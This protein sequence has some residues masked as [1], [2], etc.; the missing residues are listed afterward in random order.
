MNIGIVIT[1][2]R[3]RNKIIKALKEEQVD[4][5]FINLIDDNWLD[6]FKGQFDGYLIYPPSFPYEWKNLFF[7]RLYYINDLIKDRMTPNL[8]AISIYE[9]KI[10][11]HDFYK[12]NN[13]PHI[14]ANTFYNLQDALEYSHGCKLP[15][16]VKEDEGS[17]SVGV[18][19]FKDRKKL[20][21]M[22]KKSFY[23]N[24]QIT[25]KLNFKNIKSKLSPYKKNFNIALN[26]KWNY[27]PSNTKRVG[28][29]HIQSYEKIKY[30]WRIIR[31]GESYF[32][33]KK[34]EDEEGFHSGSLRKG[35]G[36]IPIQ[37]LN[38]VKEVSD[39]INFDNT[40]FDLFETS[41]GEL[42]FNEIQVMFGVSTEEQLIVNNVPGRYIF[43]NDNWIFDPGNYSRN[44]CNNMRIKHLK[45]ILEN[46]K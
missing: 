43:R 12:A 41:N 2:E 9:S 16:V 17:S 32:G 5:T 36:E 45:K 20:I 35:W 25:K 30:E 39:K 31:I 8:Q 37:I 40:S 22:I 3:S 11:M 10:A 4:Y 46:N 44:G 1:T 15:V 29:I 24:N 23:F 38:L 6:Y 21:K 7:K 28:F 18:N 13:I 14:K 42:Y 26:T 34:L 27:F 33:H 19:I